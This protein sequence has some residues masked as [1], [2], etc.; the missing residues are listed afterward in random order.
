MCLYPK[1][2]K[3]P[4]YKATKKNRG[5]VPICNDE[6]KKNYTNRVRKMYGVYEA[7]SERM[8]IQNNRR[9]KSA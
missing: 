5:I 1:L 7:K 9:F 2:I 4:R 6:R 8:E 3:N